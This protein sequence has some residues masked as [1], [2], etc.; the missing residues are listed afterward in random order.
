MGAEVEAGGGSNPGPIGGADI[1]VDQLTGTWFGTLE[2]GTGDMHVVQVTVSGAS[3]TSIVVDGITQSNTGT[4]AKENGQVFSYLLTDGTIGGF[5]VD[6]SSTYLAFVNDWFEFGVLQKGATA[7]P[8]YVLNDIDGS[9]SGITI[10]TDF[11]TFTQHTSTA[12]CTTLTCSASASS[13]ISSTA[14]FIGPFDAVHGRWIGTYTNSASSSG[15]VNGFLSADK[16]FAGT[17]A[18]DA[19]GFFPG[20]CSFSAWK[21]TN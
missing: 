4:I 20:D 2:D 12:T 6:P 3:I 19:A 13:G 5:F 10:V 17:W 18:C 9:W 15:P 8:S 11:D 1:T 16:Q 7:L 14:S 21:R